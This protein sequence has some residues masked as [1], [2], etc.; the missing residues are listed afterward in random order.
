MQI[1]NTYTGDATTDEEREAYFANVAE[2]CDRAAG[3]GL[4]IGMETD[5]NM[6]PTAEIGVA[7]LDRIDR[8]DVL[9]FNYDP[10]NVV[11]YTGADPL[12]DIR[13]ALPRLVHFH[14]KDKIGGKGVFNS[15]RPAT[16]SST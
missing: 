8:P 12:T 15:R 14:F 13:F 2:L 6:L 1:V 10:G 4:K 7:I 16:A 3:H 9:G 5:S 11:Y